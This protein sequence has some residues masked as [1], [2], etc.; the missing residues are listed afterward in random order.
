MWA[1]YARS[2]V[3]NEVTALEGSLVD[4]Q[5]HHTVLKVLVPA[6]LSLLFSYRLNMSLSLFCVP[7]SLPPSF[8]HTLSASSLAL[9]LSLSRSL[10]QRPP[11][12]SFSLSAC[13]YTNRFQNPKP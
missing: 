1:K 5:R 3:E 13:K 9:R 11:P 8:T 10:S 7:Y 6:Y 2:L 4:L 12:S